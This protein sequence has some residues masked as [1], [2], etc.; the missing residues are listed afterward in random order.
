MP[1]ESFKKRFSLIVIC[2]TAAIGGLLFGYDTGVIAGAILFIKKEFYLTIFQEQLIIAIISFG[3][4][5][6][7]LIAGPLSDRFGRKTIVLASSIL[8]ILSSCMLAWSPNVNWLIIGRL[9]VGVAIG[10]SS[11]TAPLYIAELAPFPHR[12]ALVS[13]NQLFITIGI[14]LAFVAGFILANTLAWRTMFFIAA[15]P[16]TLQFIIMLFF[17][18]SPRWLISKGRR[19]KALKILTRFRANSDDARLETEHIDRR[20]QEDS[21]KWSELIS[22]KIR[23]ALIAG[24]GLTIIQQATG[25]NSVLYYA[26]TIFKMAAFTST[27]AAIYASVWVGIV[28]VAM[29]IVALW[30]IDKMGRKPLLI[31]GLS[32]IIIS[33]IILG[34]GFLLMG[35]SAIMGWVSL[36]S[37]MVFIG[38]FAISLGVN[39]WLINSEIY[40][41]KIR[42]KAMGIVVC[43]NWAVNFIITLTFLDL[44]YSAGKTGT[45]WI[46]ALI[47]IFGL[48]FIVKR[49]PETK[50][51]SLE[52]IEEFWN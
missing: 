23:P 48:W 3:A 22:R 46:Y 30:L 38:S 27:K 15:I 1:L 7:A 6:G 25:I 36:I 39:G 29:T 49:I 9:I 52:E 40:P 44:I 19:D 43:V 18:E 31:L 41:L 14:L 32:G 8:F 45:F 21:S 26:P 42:G 2:C 51:K 35:E 11:A 20:L 17:P 50:C 16:A 33:L 4:I 12:G 37:L 34:L 24:L 10:A 28:N 5:I 13:I 47:G